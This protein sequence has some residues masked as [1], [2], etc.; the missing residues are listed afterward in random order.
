MTA[1]TK[2][3]TVTI[4]TRRGATR[5]S[6]ETLFHPVNGH[7]VTRRT[8]YDTG[9]YANNLRGRATDVPVEVVALWTERRT[10]R[11]GPYWALYCLETEYTRKG[12]TA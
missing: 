10:D 8:R 3:H 9:K 4:G 11:D 6:L 7:T 5:A 1:T 12:G 2:I